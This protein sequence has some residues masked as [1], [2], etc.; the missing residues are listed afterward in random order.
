LKACDGLT[1]DAV[2]QRIHRA[3]VLGVCEAYKIDPTTV[4]EIT[5]RTMA[6]FAEPAASLSKQTFSSGRRFDKL[7]VEPAKRSRWRFWS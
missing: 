6:L 4:Q 7:A 1:I 2:W 5:N 3:A